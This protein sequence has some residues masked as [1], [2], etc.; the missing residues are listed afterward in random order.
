MVGWATKNHSVSNP[1]KNASFA[2]LSLLIFPILALT[3]ILSPQPYEY[4]NGGRDHGLYVNTGIHIARTGGIFIY[5]SELA[6]VP[7]ESKHLLINPAVTNE[8]SLLP[9]TWSQGRRL[10]GGMTIRDLERGIV[11]PQSFHLYPVWIAIFAAIG[12]TSFALMTTIVMSILGIFSVYI[13]V[14]R[15]FK[16]PIGLLTSFLLT[17]SLAQVWYTRTPSA[18]ILL[19]PLFWS[20]L[21][22]FTLMLTTNDRYAAILAGL[23]FGLMHLTKIDTVFVFIV[24]VIFLL[25]RWF[26]NQFPRTYLYFVIPYAFLSLQ[27]TLHAF[28]IATIYFLEQMTR[29]LLPEP[30]SQAVIKAA[31]GYNYPVDILRRLLSQ[32][33]LFIFITLLSFGILLCIAQRFRSTIG[34]KLTFVEHNAYQGKVVVSFIFVMLVMG[35]HLSPIIQTWLA[36]SPVPQIAPFFQ[37]MDG[38]VHSQQ[39][40]TFTK[41]YLTPLGAFLAFVGLVQVA[42]DR[43]IMAN[44]QIKST[45]TFVWL[46]LII[47]I[48][49][50]FILGSGTYPDHFW[51]IR[52]YVPIVLPALIMFTAYMLWHLMPKNRQTWA[53]GLLPM[54]LAGMLLIGH[55][56]SLRPFLK[57]ADYGGMIDQT[58][59]IAESFPEDAVLLFENTFA[60]GRVAAPLWQVFGRTVFLLEEGAIADPEMIPAIEYWQEN[61]RDVFWLGNGSDSPTLYENIVADYEGQRTW[62]LSW[63]ERPADYLPMRTGLFLSTIDVHRLVSADIDEQRSVSTITIAYGYHETDTVPVTGLY[64]VYLLPALAPRRWTSGQVAIQIPVS[65]NLTQLSIMMANGRPPDITPAEVSVYLD[66]TYLNTV[67]VIG[68]SKSYTFDIPQE[69]LFSTETSE[70]RLEMDPWIP[71]QTNYNADQRELGVYLDW[72]KL[73]TTENND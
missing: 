59:Q 8:R 57:F 72:I 68:E 41:W 63:A 38:P 61:G 29:V 44:N 12:G 35:I 55:E 60:T 28:F 31:T 45:S 9:A 52:R 13:A 67:Q 36:I 18:E 16:Q 48:L 5:D 49:P 47:N 1:L 73:I 43:S 50:F 56:Q 40:V 53:K 51:A 2:P 6:A 69:L 10:P 58:E 65:N 4:I 46:L 66:D 11:T 25:Y 71:A 7:S 32:N 22:T 17:I 14:A 42:S 20:G 33:I 30:I 34:E 39:F 64:D 37:I 27:A 19:Q 54:G 62:L 70:L 15:L 23:S 24:I 3:V 26:R 21:F